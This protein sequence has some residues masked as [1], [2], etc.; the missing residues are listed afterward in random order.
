MSHSRIFS[1]LRLY[2]LYEES[3]FLNWSDWV[4]MNF[5]SYYGCGLHDFFL[6]GYGFGVHGFPYGVPGD[7]VPGR[8]SSLEVITGTSFTLFRFLLELLVAFFKFFCSSIKAWLLIYDFYLLWS[9]ALFVLL[10]QILSCDWVL[11]SRLVQVVFFAFVC[12][13]SFSR[14]VTYLCY[15]MVCRYQLAVLVTD[16]KSQPVNKWGGLQLY[17]WFSLGRWQRS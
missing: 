1:Y 5:N 3:E 4:R 17:K 16:P 13:Y 2:T 11:V 12:E 10:C 9:F 14:W 6:R 7:L 15:N 8:Y